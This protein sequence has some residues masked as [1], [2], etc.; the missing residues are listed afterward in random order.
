MTAM[1]APQHGTETGPQRP[2]HERVVCAGLGISVDGRDTDAHGCAMKFARAGIGQHGPQA[3]RMNL[4]DSF[5]F[6]GDRP[7]H[8]F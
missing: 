1:I 5:D 2:Q 4:S 8:D 3:G 6:H 7:L